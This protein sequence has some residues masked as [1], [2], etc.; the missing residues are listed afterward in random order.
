[1]YEPSKIRKS[2]TESVAAQ[3]LAELERAYVDVK[4]YMA[5]LAELL[6]LPQ[7]DRARLTSPT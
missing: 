1:M 7:L 4:I 5:E 2:A 6:D 3:L